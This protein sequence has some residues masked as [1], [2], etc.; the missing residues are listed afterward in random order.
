MNEEIDLLDLFFSFWSKRVLIITVVIVCAFLGLFYTRFLVTPEYA[1]SV[2]LVLGKSYDENLHTIDGDTI[3]QSD[4]VLNQKLVSTYSELMKSKRV[5]NQVIKN[6]NL[7][8]TYSQIN[9]GVSV[10]SVKDSNVIKV[11]V[12]TTNPEVSAK[13]ADEMVVVFTDVIAETLKI[14]N[15]AVIDG[16]EVNNKPVN[17]SYFKNMFIFAFIGFALVAAVLFMIYYFDNTI[18][19]EEGVQKITDLPVLASIPNVSEVKGGKKHA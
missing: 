3:T 15:V 5:I 6:L 10:S 14:Q 9:N 19:T 11:S 12:T 17:V 16:A 13:V 7:N 8:M 2:T 18:K 4:V 1:S